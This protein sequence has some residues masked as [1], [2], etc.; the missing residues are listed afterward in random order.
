MPMTLP[1]RRFSSHFVEGEPYLKHYRRLHN[2]ISNN[3]KR[4]VDLS[5][6]NCLGQECN[7]SLKMISAESHTG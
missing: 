5:D 2:H 1:A 6:A 4:K 3:N 7:N